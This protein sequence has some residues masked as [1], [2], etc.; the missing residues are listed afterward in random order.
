[1]SLPTSESSEPNARLLAQTL[2]ARLAKHGR[3]S[4]RGTYSLNICLISADMEKLLP[5]A[6]DFA[7]ASLG[8]RP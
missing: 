2:E 1:M 7:E 4:K 5:N 8:G 6:Y 3:F